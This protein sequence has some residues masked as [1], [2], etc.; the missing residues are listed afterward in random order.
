[1][2]TNSAK[3]ARATGR[4]AEHRQ[5]PFIAEQAAVAVVGLIVQSVL[6]ALSRGLRKGRELA[7]APGETSA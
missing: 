1:M 5:R 6:N 3:Y 7:T 4:S 2:R